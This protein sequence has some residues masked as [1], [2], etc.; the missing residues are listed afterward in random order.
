LSTDSDI[1]PTGIT[2]DNIHLSELT[3]VVPTTSLA[4]DSNRALI[5][6]CTDPKV[7]ELI[8]AATAPNTLRAYEGDIAHFLAWGGSIPAGPKI[9][10]EYFAAHSNMRGGRNAQKCKPKRTGRHCV[11]QLR[12]TYKTAAL[13]LS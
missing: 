11:P 13:P 4:V 1:A 12:A 3:S 5:A 10:A 2:F 8:A 6:D 9:V 7:L